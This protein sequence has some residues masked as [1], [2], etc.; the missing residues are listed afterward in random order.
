MNIK[1][2]NPDVQVEFVA[3]DNSFFLEIPFAQL[4]SDFAVL[5]GVRDVMADALRGNK[6]YYYPLHV[7]I[8]DM[9]GTLSVNLA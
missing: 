9:I 1:T 5:G 8:G 4:L 3:S 2:Y 7:R 6:V